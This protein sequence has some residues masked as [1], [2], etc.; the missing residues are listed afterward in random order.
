MNFDLSLCQPVLDRDPVLYLDLTE[1][2]R[3]GDGRVLCSM[4]HGALVAFTN[5]LDGPDYG[6]TMFA[7]DMETARALCAL[8][9]PGPGFITVHERF[10]F[11]LLKERFGFSEVNV[12]WQVGY[13]STTPLPLSELGLE[14]RLL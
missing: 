9:P 5:L 10:Y 11:D 2:V 13:L 6:Y 4:P 7:D 12:C 1:A 14:I 8:I 3:R